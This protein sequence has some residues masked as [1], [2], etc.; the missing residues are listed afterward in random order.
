LKHLIVRETYGHRP[1]AAVRRRS[2]NGCVCSCSSALLWCASTACGK[3]STSL[4]QRTP[5]CTLS[6]CVLR[7]FHTFFGH[8]SSSRSHTARP[9]IHANANDRCT[10]RGGSTPRSP[11]MRARCR[12]RSPPASTLRASP[13]TAATWFASQT[14]QPSCCCFSGSDRPRTHSHLAVAAAVAAT[15]HSTRPKRPRKQQRNM[16]S[17]VRSQ[18]RTQITRSHSAASSGVRSGGCRWRPPLSSSCRGSFASAY[19]VDASCSLQR[20]RPRL[21]ITTNSS[22]SS[23]R[24]KENP[25]RHRQPEGQHQQH[26]QRC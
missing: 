11:P 19:R 14:T 18:I 16:S 24:S 9:T 17:R 21:P 15:Q 3:Q 13:R 26:Q 4:D 25:Q 23:S 12:W 22:S 8:C 10:Q 7:P 5:L 1:G 20:R 2:G 6:S